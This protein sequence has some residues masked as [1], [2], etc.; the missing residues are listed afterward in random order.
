MFE[1]FE[2]SH[3]LNSIIY[4][5][6]MQKTPFSLLLRQELTRAL[7]FGVGFFAILSLGF[8]SV[9]Y[10]A[11]WGIFGDVLNKILKSGNWEAPG[12]GTV[13]NAEKLGWKLP[14]DFV[15]AGGNRTCGAWQCVNGFDNT[16][17]N[18]TCVTP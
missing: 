3:I 16:T 10:A 11:N 17:G 1:V 9:A 18:V 7:V 6:Y 15:K 5:Q 2:L 13:K 14:V 12:D 8:V 4:Y